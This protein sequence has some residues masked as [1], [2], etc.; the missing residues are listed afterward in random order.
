MDVVFYFSFH[1]QDHGNNEL[2]D[3]QIAFYVTNLTKPWNEIETTVYDCEEQFHTQ[4]GDHFWLGATGVPLFAYS[5]S[6]VQPHHYDELM[7]C[8]Q[9]VFVLMD[10]NCV[11]SDVFVLGVNTNTL[12]PAEI[13]CE[14]TKD[15]YEQQQ[16]EKLR[17][18]LTTY[19]TTTNTVAPSKKI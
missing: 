3:R 14:R 9:Q 12:E 19:I 11:V 17:T 8:W 16:A 10:P 18:T 5:S 15:L 1:E 6:Y 2:K 7:Q 13:I 4:Y